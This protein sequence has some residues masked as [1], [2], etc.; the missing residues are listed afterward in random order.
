MRVIL[1]GL[2][3]V[4]KSY[5]G[6]KLGEILEIP[7]IPYVPDFQETEVGIHK[8]LIKVH[9]QLNNSIIEGSLKMATAVKNYLRQKNYISFA[10]YMTCISM[11]D[12]YINYKNDIYIYITDDYENI[13]RR[14]AERARPYEFDTKLSIGDLLDLDKYIESLFLQSDYEFNYT[15][16]KY[17]KRHFIVNRADFKTE[18]DLINLLCQLIIDRVIKASSHT[19]V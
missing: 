3:G 8:S 12:N 6:E 15:K 11:N 19:L 17:V 1:D 7:F 18:D 4:G 13:I 14:R 2:S 9:N 5:L 10:D 16:Y